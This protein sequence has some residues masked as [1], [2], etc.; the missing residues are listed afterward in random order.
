MAG[1]AGT[2]VGD[3]AVRV[4]SLRAAFPSAARFGSP[5]GVGGCGC[6][7]GQRLCIGDESGRL[8][9]LRLG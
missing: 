1:G 4:L 9:L 3:G 5:D 6:V 2:E 7:T 8:L